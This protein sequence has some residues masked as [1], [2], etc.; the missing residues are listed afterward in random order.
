[1]RASKIAVSILGI[2]FAVSCSQVMAS[3]KSNDGKSIPY[4]LGK[5]KGFRVKHLKCAPNEKL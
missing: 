4:P 2:L 5:W 3:Q 1:M